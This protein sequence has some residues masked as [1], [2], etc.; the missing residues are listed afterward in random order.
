M[1]PNSTTTVGQDIKN[2]CMLS[3]SSKIT[4]VA[5]NCMFVQLTG[6]QP[7]YDQEGYVGIKTVSFLT[8]TNYAKSA[9]MVLSLGFGLN[10]EV[11]RKMDFNAMRVE[12]FVPYAISTGSSNLI[13]YFFGTGNFALHHDRFPSDS[14]FIGLDPASNVV[15]SNLPQTPTASNTYAIMT[16]S[17]PQEF[18][19][20]GAGLDI[21]SL[22]TLLTKKSN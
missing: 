20:V 17:H 19:S 5:D 14:N 16:Q 12:G 18:Y 10:N 11:N 22:I 9:P 1:L 15:V 2:T 3:G 13:L 7:F 8:Q 4:G 21:R 6:S